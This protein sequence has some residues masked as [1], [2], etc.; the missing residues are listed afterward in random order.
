MANGALALIGEPPITSLDDKMRAAARYAKRFFAEERDELLRSKD[1]EFA[2]NSVVPPG[3]VSPNPHWSWRYTMPADCIAV[4]QIGDFDDSTDEPDWE[5]PTTGDDATVATVVDTNA[6][7]PRIYYTRRL[8]NPAQWDEAF[9]KTFKTYLAIKLNPL[10]GR[11]KNKTAEL[12]GNA[13]KQEFRAA[14][15][16]SQQRNGDT[17]NRTTSWVL[18]RWGYVN[19]RR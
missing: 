12:L 9:A 2:R 10:I 19:G 15:R 3:V 6:V 4:L 14:Q 16:D 11:D 7:A 5:S 18:A 8:V 1:W 17:L 13:E